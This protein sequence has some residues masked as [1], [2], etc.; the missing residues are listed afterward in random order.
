MQNLEFGAVENRL[1]DIT[2]KANQLVFAHKTSYYAYRGHEDVLYPLVH[3][4]DP[5]L[6]NDDIRVEKEQEDKAYVTSTRTL[7]EWG[8]DKTLRE[9]STL[10]KTL[11]NEEIISRF[12]MDDKLPIIKNA[13]DIV[14]E[15]IIHGWF[16]DEKDV[17]IL[18]VMFHG[19]KQGV[20]YLATT[21]INQFLYQDRLKLINF[22]QVFEAELFEARLINFLKKINMELREAIKDENY[23][24]NFFD[25][26]ARKLSDLLGAV[27]II[28]F[29]NHTDNNSDIDMLGVSGRDI[30]KVFEKKSIKKNSLLEFIDGNRED[31]TY[32]NHKD[33]NSNYAKELSNVEYGHSINLMMRDEYNN[34]LGILMILDKDRPNISQAF[35]EE[36]IFLLGEI[37]E[38]ITHYFTVKGKI[39]I[40]TSL[41]AHDV[42][43]TFRTIYSTKERLEIYL[44]DIPNKK[45]KDY[46]KKLMDIDVAVTS[47]KEMLDYITHDKA[48]SKST[49]KTPILAY[50]NYF[51]DTKDIKT[52][53]NIRDTIANVIHG[54]DR[55]LKKNYIKF[56]FIWERDLYNLSLWI[57]RSFLHDVLSNLIDNVVKYGKPSSI[58]HINMIENP[59][60]YIVRVENI[61]IILNQEAQDNPNI[62]FEKNIRCIPEDKTSL[63]DGKGIGLYISKETCRF[64]GA[65]LTLEYKEIDTQWATYKFEITFPK[66][67]GSDDNS[68]TRR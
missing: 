58:L 1:K 47:G 38:S 60:D 18:P 44:K 61:G 8:R 36:A 37:Q 9:K 46:S 24:K 4:R 30:D 13:K 32:I 26:I 31:I 22:I 39:E 55:D 3:K 16:A 40:I 29:W 35:E 54:K 50:L 53:V 51:N 64:W 28:I 23:K 2:R 34:L 33:S 19:R 62:V 43:S 56:N 48:Q 21:H 68:Y 25:Y 67:L 45:R 63:N 59:A 52:K 65:D 66:W 10:Y 57:H 49:E 17:L 5:W 6:R 41:L 15:T 12:F 14:G 7:K 11:D 20:L 27:G 42:N